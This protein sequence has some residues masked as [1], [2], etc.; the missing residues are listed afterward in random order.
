MEVVGDD[1]DVVFVKGTSLPLGLPGADGEIPLD[2]VY[3][4]ISEVTGLVTEAEVFVYGPADDELA[5]IYDDGDVPVGPTGM[6]EFPS[7]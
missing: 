7:V 5:E 3:E 2:E 6:D 1:P 4:V